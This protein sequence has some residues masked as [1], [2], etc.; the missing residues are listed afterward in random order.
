MKEKL[1]KLECPVC[2]ERLYRDKEDPT[3]R[4]CSQESHLATVWLNPEYGWFP[5]GPE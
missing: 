5:E 4:R 3:I 1:L 2:G